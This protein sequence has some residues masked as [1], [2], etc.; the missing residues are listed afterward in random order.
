MR[1]CGFKLLGF[2]DETEFGGGTDFPRSM[3][4]HTNNRRSDRMI[5]RLT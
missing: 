5:A 2:R 1:F 4:I 3:F